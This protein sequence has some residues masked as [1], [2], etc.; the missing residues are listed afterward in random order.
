[1]NLI[2]S[3]YCTTLL[4][5]EVFL[6]PRAW[7][8]GNKISK[9]SQ[10]VTTNFHHIL[11]AGRWLQGLKHCLSCIT[12]NVIPVNDNLDDAVPYLRKTQ[13]LLMEDS[14]YMQL[15]Q[16]FITVYLEKF[17]LSSSRPQLMICSTWKKDIPIIICIQ[18]LNKQINI[19]KW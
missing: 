2:M 5:E 12:L 11:M 13:Q 14:A 6:L 15:V 10:D 3:H 16:V 7:I 19:R 18:Y 17:L 8:T 9:F 4:F 1:M